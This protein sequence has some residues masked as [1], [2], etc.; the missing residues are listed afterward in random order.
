MPNWFKKG[1]RKQ[2][3]CEKFQASAIKTQQTLHMDR[4][5]RN[6]YTHSLSEGKEV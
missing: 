2:R 3:V 4:H 1:I 5:T 6:K